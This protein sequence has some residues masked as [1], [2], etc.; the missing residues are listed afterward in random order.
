M[1][2]TVQGVEGCLQKPVGGAALIVCG[3]TRPLCKKTTVMPSQGSAGERPPS[4]EVWEGFM[5][6]GTFEQSQVDIPQAEKGPRHA[7]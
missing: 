3:R 1:L 7:K 6:E 2:G 5:E 4:E